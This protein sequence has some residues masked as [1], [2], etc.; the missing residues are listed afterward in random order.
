MAD[1]YKLALVHELEWVL[2]QALQ[3][4]QNWSPSLVYM[5]PLVP[6][7]EI[8]SAEYQRASRTAPGPRC[9]M[10]TYCQGNTLC[11]IIPGASCPGTVFT[12]FQTPGGATFGNLCILCLDLATS[13]TGRRGVE[14]RAFLNQSEFRVTPHIL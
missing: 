1:A 11:M 2:N 8:V 4:Q 9:R 3:E 14:S 10:G 5:P 7:P 12:V 6:V 13:K